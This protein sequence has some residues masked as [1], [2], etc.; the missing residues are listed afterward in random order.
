[1][2]AEGEVGSQAVPVP[3]DPVGLCT[4]SVLVAPGRG[5]GLGAPT[6]AGVAA[7]PCMMLHILVPARGSAPPDSCS[8]TASTSHFTEKP[9]LTEFSEHP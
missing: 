4:L 5:G 6:M 3:V 8:H 9:D 2:L 1:M 7:A